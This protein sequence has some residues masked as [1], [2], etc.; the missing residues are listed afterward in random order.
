[1]RRKH[2]AKNRVRLLEQKSIYA[3]EHKQQKAEYD[4]QYR[5]RN[6]K[7]IR[8]YQSEWNKQSI[9]HKIV[10]NLRRRV[11]RALKGE[12][13]SES[14]LSLLGC[15]INY[16]KEYLESKFQQ[17]M[18]W[19]NYGEWHIDHIKPCSAFDLSD[20][21]QQKECFAYTNLQPL[22]A[23]DNLKK[24]YKYEEKKSNRE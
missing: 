13:K 19:D 17:G 2:Y 6:K 7:R 22:W 11:H 21:V 5:Q 1:M 9:K 23:I 18:T 15:S 10:R 12:T 14:T 24:A 3:A 16:L 8:A 4:K 20:P